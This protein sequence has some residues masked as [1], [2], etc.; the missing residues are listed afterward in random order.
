M[1]NYSKHVG[2]YFEKQLCSVL[3]SIFS[4]PV[5]TVLIQRTVHVTLSLRHSISCSLRDGTEASILVYA[6]KCGLDWGLF[7]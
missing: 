4:A 3:L 5:K 1:S 6:V 7:L 2:N